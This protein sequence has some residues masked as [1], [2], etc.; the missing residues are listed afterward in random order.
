MVQKQ[1]RHRF[2]ERKNTMK[3][4][5]YT[6]KGLNVNFNKRNRDNLSYKRRKENLAY[7]S[8]IQESYVQYA[9]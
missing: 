6:K 8:L 3:K 9:E 1:K 2:A 4:T 5:I 7:M